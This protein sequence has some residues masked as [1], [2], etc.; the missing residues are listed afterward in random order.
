MRMVAAAPPPADPS[1]VQALD[2]EKRAKGQQKGIK[3]NGME[4]P[5]ETIIPPANMTLSFPTQRSRQKATAKVL[6][7]EHKPDTP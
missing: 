5:F 3:S 1:R 2:E 6:P 7:V 4:H